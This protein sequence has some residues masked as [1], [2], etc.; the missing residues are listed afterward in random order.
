MSF[1]PY[2]EIVT[3][4]N[5]PTTILAVGILEIK[6]DEEGMSSIHMGKNFPRIHLQYLNGKKLTLQFDDEA[7]EVALNAHKTITEVLRRN[8]NYFVKEKILE[9]FFKID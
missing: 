7:S 6:Y 1:E 4:F 3:R 8:I 5:R 2:L 9:Q